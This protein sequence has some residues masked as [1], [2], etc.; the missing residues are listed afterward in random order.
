MDAKAIA[1]QWATGEEHLQEPTP[2]ENTRRYLIS[3]YSEARTVGDD[4]ANEISNETA[5]TQV[6][7]DRETVDADTLQRYGQD[8]GISEASSSH[9]TQGESPIWF[10]SVTPREDRAYFEQGIETYY[11][12]HVHEVDNKTPMAQDYQRV[13]DLIH[14]RIDPVPELA[15]QLTP[16]LARVD[17]TTHQH[18]H[19]F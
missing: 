16:D 5:H 15:P 2:E 10:Y 14:V 8:Y 1:R 19:E 4:I 3:I 12:L 13:A 18:D 6:E 7:I 9:L 11:S 17:L